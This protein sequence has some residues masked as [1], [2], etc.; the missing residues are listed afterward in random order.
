MAL[1]SRSTVTSKSIGLQHTGQSSMKRCLRPPLGSTATKLVSEQRG[2]LYAA[3]LSS[4]T[5]VLSKLRVRT[6]RKGKQELCIASSAGPLD[7]CRDLPSSRQLGSASDR[8]CFKWNRHG[9]L[10]DGT[11][12]V[13]VF[14]MSARALRITEN[15]KKRAPCHGC[16]S[17]PRMQ[18][19]QLQHAEKQ[20]DDNRAPGTFEVLPLLPP[21]QS[22]PRNQITAVPSPISGNT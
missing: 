3:S 18:T 20:A 6:P 21:P 10:T 1:P 4:G 19:S 17:L 11:D 8:H 16:V 5:R 22:P 13:S 2:Q 15:G 14:F 7:P 12:R 9:I